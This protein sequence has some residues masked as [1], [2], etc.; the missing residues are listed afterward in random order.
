MA[1]LQSGQASILHMQ[2]GRRVCRYPWGSL[3][4]KRAACTF[5]TVRC[6]EAVS[7][8]LCVITADM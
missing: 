3:A 4:M 1:F 2:R 6:R 8:Q 7:F 5:Q